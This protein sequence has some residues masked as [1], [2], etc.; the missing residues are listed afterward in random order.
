MT[1]LHL[2]QVARRY[3]GL[4]ALHPI[5]L[6]IPIGARHAV[7]GA[8][9]AGKSTLFHLIAGTVHPTGGRVLL[10]DRD[11]TRL[12]PAARAHR[13]I[14]RTWQH[15]AVVDR[16]TAAANVALAITRHAT[17][18]TRLRLIR[19]NHTAALAH[20]VLA[21]AD[22]ADHAETPAG[23]LPY[24]LQRRLELTVALAAK[25]RLLLLDEPS[26]G[27]DPDETARL[28]TTIRTLPADITVLLIDHQLNLV[29]DVADTVTVLHH[30]RHTATGTPR[31]IRA[32]PEVQAAYLTPTPAAAKALKP[33]TDRRPPDRPALLRVR[34]L[35]V[36]YH[37]APVLHDLDFDIAEGQVTA[38]LGRNGAGK[39][40]L[41][42]ALAGLIPSTAGSVE[43]AG[44]RL[45]DQPHRI[46]R[47]GVSIVPQGR[48]L[49]DLTVDEHLATA[50]TAAHHRST[51]GHRW[52]RSEILALLPPLNS[53]LRHHA[54]HLSGGEQQ[55]L[56]L[57]RALLGNPRLLLLDE[58]SEGLAPIIVAQLTEAVRRIAAEGVTV[59]LAEQNHR[60]ALD[61]AD[62][63]L[64]LQHGHVVLDLTTAALTEPT[65]R[66]QLD[67]L[68]GVADAGSSR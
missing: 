2:D 68:L 36:G 49:F 62:R 46:A 27:L 64:I 67:S 10:D 5:T 6:D 16:L 57:A 66:Q 40:T 25:P 58:P 44:T 32:N 23:A 24:G 33:Q 48:R 59:L 19:R 17:R 38:V 9:G 60:L 18:D 65:T 56:A 39:T 61:V 12:S 11:V 45:P 22:L 47:T 42:N 37:G 53:R 21:T 31:A 30:G 4:H 43:L 14:S 26:A 55:M 52:A 41:L 8:N 34:G 15:P 3:G 54:A 13:G 1:L 7:I 51:G 28:V 63:V 50:E 35:R 20:A 29:W